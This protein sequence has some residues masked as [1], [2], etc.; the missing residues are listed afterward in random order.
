[1]AL[2]LGSYHYELLLYPKQ[3]N[4]AP[5]LWNLDGAKKALTSVITII[6]AAKSGRIELPSD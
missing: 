4:Q 6:A 1:M 2:R 5:P 3:S